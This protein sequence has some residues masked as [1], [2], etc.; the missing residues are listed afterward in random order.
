MWNSQCVPASVRRYS[1]HWILSWYGQ[2]RNFWKKKIVLT[3][4]IVSRFKNMN[5]A[6]ANWIFLMVN[7]NT[8]FTWSIHWKSSQKSMIVIVISLE[9][10]RKWLLTNPSA[11]YLDL[12][13]NVLIHIYPNIWSFQPYFLIRSGHFLVMREDFSC[14]GYYQTISSINYGRNLHKHSCSTKISPNIRTNHCALL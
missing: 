13:Q 10:G 8:S 14:D 9:V 5:E 2:W 11:L 12:Y 4:W 6:S 3:S 7:L 1:Q